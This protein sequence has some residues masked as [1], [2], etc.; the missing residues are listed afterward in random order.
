MQA[1]WDT[2]LYERRYSQLLANE[3]RPTELTRF[4]AASA[5]HLSDWLNSIPIP[6]LC[7]KLDDASFRIICGLRLGL[8]LCKP[9]TCGCGQAVD[10]L[11]QHGLSCRQA[12]GTIP[13]Y[14]QVNDLINR[15]LGTALIPN[16]REPGGLVRR[17]MKIPDEMTLVPW[18]RGKYL[19]W[20]YTCN[21]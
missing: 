9:Y 1:Q 8:P 10:E 7:L 2:P 18:V 5:E 14:S 13:R 21:E 20:D 17:D 15:A 16:R 6:G 3:T 11:G 4:R 12:K 19:V